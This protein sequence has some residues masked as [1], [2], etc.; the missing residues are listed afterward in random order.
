MAGAA[1]ETAPGQPVFP[2]GPA[3]A[4]NRPA[5]ASARAFP[6]APGEV[7]SHQVLPPLHSRSAVGLTDL[8]PPEPFGLPVVAWVGIAI[9]AAIL[10]LF[11]VSTL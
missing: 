5:P 9:Y 11:L 1:A 10:L 6:S 3:T 7:V 4:Q 8:V 2:A